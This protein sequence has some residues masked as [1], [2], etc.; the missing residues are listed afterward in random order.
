MVWLLSSVSILKKLRGGTPLH[1]KEM[2]KYVF[3]N[4]DALHLFVE[5]MKDKCSEIEIF[6]VMILKLVL[7]MNVQFW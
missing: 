2:R 6:A 3:F 5:V 1:L 4:H 7:I